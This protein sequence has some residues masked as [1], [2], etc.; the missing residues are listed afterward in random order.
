MIAGRLSQH[1]TF[2]QLSMSGRLFAANRMTAIK[3]APGEVMFQKGEPRHTMV[4]LL[5]GTVQMSIEGVG[6][7]AENRAGTFAIEHHKPCD[8]G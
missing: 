3:L 2:K 5:E 1:E 4:F 8:K 7:I 6:K